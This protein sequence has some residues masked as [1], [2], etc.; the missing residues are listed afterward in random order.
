MKKVNSKGLDFY[1]FEQEPFSKI[2]HGFVTRNGGVSPEPWDSLNLSTTGGDSKEN[3]IENRK[4]IF[5]SIGRP[6]E[7]IYDTWQIHSSRI[8]DTHTQRGL[9]NE[10]EKADGIITSQSEVTLFMRFADCVPV[11]F[12]D[13]IKHVIGLAHAGWKGTVNKIVVKMIKTMV[14]NYGSIPADIKAGLGPCICR[15]HYKI[16]EDVLL[17]VQKRFPNDWQQII[18]YDDESIHFDLTL[19]NKILL[20][21]EGLSEIF[22]S[23]LCTACNTEEWYSHRAESGATGRFGAFIAIE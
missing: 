8:I 18:S 12:Y 14:K 5:E 11:L 6:V 9:D 10:P 4:R 20:E 22:V 23:N 19:A 16:K 1:C 7:S 13:P 21:K 2:T 3:V 17:K 15:K